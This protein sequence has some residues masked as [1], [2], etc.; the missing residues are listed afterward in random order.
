VIVRRIPMLA[1]TV[2]AALGIVAVASDDEPGVAPTFASRPQPWMPAAPTE[3][4]LTTTWFCPGVPATGAEGTAGEVVISNSTDGP[5]DARVTLL[6]EAGQ[7][8]TQAV[9]VPALGRSTV[10][11]ADALTAPFVG[12]TVEVDGTGALVEQRA[13]DPAGTSIAPC[14]TMPASNWYL[15]EGFTADESTEQLVLMNPFDQNVIVDVSFATDEGTR[16]PSQLQ[17]FPIAP[18][19]VQVIDV[20]SIAARDEPQVAVQVSAQRGATLV[21]GR[22]Q[23]YRGAGRLGY[24]MTLASPVLRSQWWFANGL[25]GPGVTER[26]SIY[27]PGDEDVQVQPLFLGLPT[28]TAVTVDPIDVPAG[29]LVTYTSDTAAGLPDGRHGMLFDTQ[30]SGQALVVERAIT[31][32]IDDIPTTSVLLGGLSREDGLVPNVWTLGVGPGQP[33]EDALIV[34][35]TTNAD[36]TVTVQAVTPAGLVN[37]PGLEAVPLPAAGILPIS[38]TD[39]AALDAQLVLQATAPVFVERSIPRESGAQ[40]RTTSWAVPVV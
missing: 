3:P 20:D 13:T 33:T 24:S 26:Y 19:S 2:V 18:R 5:L 8:V 9:E 32:T 12:A 34:Y 36:A 40:G 39:P 28:D 38:L 17:G 30:D 15:A 23:L 25:K 35:N 14:T 6:A 11:P 1:V 31:R 37:V 21:V 10:S 7:A 27:N 16:E 29:E 4:A 22:A